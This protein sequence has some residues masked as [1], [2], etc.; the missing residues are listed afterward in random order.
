MEKGY[1]PKWI[2]ILVIAAVII[3]IASINYVRYEIDKKIQQCQEAI[4]TNSI[5]QGA[6]INILAREDI[7]SR[8]D[9][10]AEA[11][12]LSKSLKEQIESLDALQQKE[13]SEKK[14]PKSP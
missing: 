13:D 10:F 6:L 8:D 14:Q 5:M 3:P 11:Q 7:I 2:I 4:N 1:R 9:L 12:Q